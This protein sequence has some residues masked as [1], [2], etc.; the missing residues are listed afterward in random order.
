MAL[1]RLV[2]PEGE[3]LLDGLNTCNIGLR[4]LRKNI[5]VIPQVCKFS[6]NNVVFI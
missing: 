5:S 3:M 2:E 4:D 1:L 6:R